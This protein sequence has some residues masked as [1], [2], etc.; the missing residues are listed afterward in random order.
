MEVHNAVHKSFFEAFRHFWRNCLQDNEN[1]PKAV[2][3]NSL[4]SELSNPV[5]NRG[6]L[7]ILDLINHKMD[8]FESQ[9]KQL[10][11]RLINI[12]MEGSQQKQAFEF[13]N[14]RNMNLQEMGAI[15]TTWQQQNILLNPLV[16]FNP[17]YDYN[18]PIP[19]IPISPIQ[20][21][22]TLEQ[23][24]QRVEFNKNRNSRQANEDMSTKKLIAF[25]IE[26][27]FQTFEIN[28]DLFF[29]TINDRFYDKTLDSFSM[30]EEKYNNAHISMLQAVSDVKDDWF[31][32]LKNQTA[33]KF[34]VRQQNEINGIFW[35]TYTANM[36]SVNI[37]K[38]KD[39][40]SAIALFQ[41][42]L[43]LRTSLNMP[44]HKTRHFPLHDLYASLK[45]RGSLSVYI[46]KSLDWA[47]NNS[48]PL[49]FGGLTQLPVTTVVVNSRVNF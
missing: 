24:K 25:R 44:H 29:D 34:S 33:R 26:K 23:E 35:G 48:V 27:V 31:E 11:F 42:F 47:P 12:F 41:N 38:N 16:N 18:Q 30:S 3:I 49:K 20:K 13:Q 43:G 15:I 9:F 46:K 32:F 14:V 22:T 7:D 19:V 1:K 37:L 28:N 39:I 40:D 5:P 2:I 4:I 17:R 45:T 6:W 8:T 36:I 21:L 10:N